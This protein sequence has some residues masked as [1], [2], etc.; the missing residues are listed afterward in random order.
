VK[1][2]FS[3][4]EL[5][6]LPGLPSTV[7]MINARAKRESW[8]AQKRAGRGGGREYHLSALPAETRIHLASDASQASTTRD[9]DAH[10]GGL[11]GRRL[12]L[13]QAIDDK[14]RERQCQAGLAAYMQLNATGRTRADARLAVLSA[15]D[16]FS[17]SA[18]LPAGQSLHA[19][20]A[21][22]NQGEIHIED[23]VRDLVESVHPATLYRWRKALQQE[24]AAALGGR[25]G[26]R[27]G[28]SRI[29]RQPAL[30]QFIVAMLT[31]HPHACAAQI[32]QACKSR[33]ADSD[34]EL[35][36]QRRLAAWLAT[37]KRENGQLHM[38]VSN[39]DAWKNRY[40]VAFGSA[41]EG[42]ER[43]NQ[44]W[45]FDS[46]PADVMLLDGRHSLIGIIDVY[47]RRP[48][49]LVSR[50]SKASAVALLTRRAMLSWGVPEQAKT[51]N[52]SDY[53][54]FH[55]K[56]VFAALEIEHLLCDPFSAWQK[57]HIERFFR[58]FSHDLLELCPG[59][60]G[61]DVAQRQAIE[62]RRSFS[63]RLFQKDATV[64]L[65]MT[66][67]ELQAFCDRWVEHVYM[68]REHRELGK[69]PFE[70]VSNWRGGIRAIEDER[71]LD[72]LLAEA[73]GNGQRTVGK[74]GISVEG[75]HYIAPELGEL[76]GQRVHV[77]FSEDV[78]Q[79]YV[80]DEG[81]F[82]CIAESPDHTGIS[83]QE[84][85]AHARERQKT[86]IQTAK[87]AL[88]QAARNEKT[89]DIAAEILASRA[90]DT[91]SLVAF[92]PRKTAHDTDALAAALEAAVA[93][94]HGNQPAAPIPMSPDE[95]AR[96]DELLERFEAQCEPTEEDSRVTHAQ[97]MHIERRIERG[98]DVPQDKVRGLGI[99]K[100]SPA[101]RSQSRLF[102]L[103]ELT[104]DQFLPEEDRI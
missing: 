82:V 100:E 71:A 2:W 49:L 87:R 20:C 43:L 41:S 67:D 46:T 28:T 74:K 31:D 42:V 37:W 84:V 24:G 32:Q 60:I 3:A 40:M 93:A 57:P 54:S 62:A 22:Y 1:E 47:S 48:K 86:R 69:T 81:G 104:I 90:A 38:A 66:A 101:Y 97:W 10:A 39:P 75:I 61:H 78:G 76:V 16:S 12:A 36:S 65:R 6:G 50:T 51:D 35:P 19:F 9:A 94:E 15:L 13:G 27:K 21:R 26:H 59:Y 33:F 25:Y 53:V 98:D 89:R 79:L 18:H 52:G 80:F 7:Q 72:V 103:F 23:W 14:V 44:R 56:R 99:Y 45:E 5:A 77:R 92:P 30:K 34:I 8:P 73:P 96:H 102:E 17:R 70:M 91:D 29:D 83:R 68:H 63:D 88:K 85:A 95:Q 58:T 11:A 64:E 55:I 4:A